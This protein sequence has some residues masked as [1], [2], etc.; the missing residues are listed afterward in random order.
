MIK[1]GDK[2]AQ[3]K[4]SFGMIF[5]II[6]IIFF[7]AFAFFGIRKFLG[8]HDEITSEKLIDDLNND[9]EKM[10]KSSRG[11]Q[12]VSYNVPR[13]VKSVCIKDD[14]YENIYFL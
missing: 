11:S 9:I 2:K 1:V 6:L 5:S 12:E 14:E 3:L 4:I 13:D 8:V 7:V 10:W